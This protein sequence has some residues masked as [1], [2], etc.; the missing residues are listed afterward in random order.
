MVQSAAVQGG[1]QDWRRFELQTRPAAQS[2]AQS[3][4]ADDARALQSDAA[5]PRVPDVPAFLSASQAAVLATGEQRLSQCSRQPV[6]RIN[7]FQS[8]SC[9]H[10]CAAR[11]CCKQEHSACSCVLAMCRLHRAL[12]RSAGRYLNAVRGAGL[13]APRTLDSDTPLGGLPCTLKRIDLNKQCRC[14]SVAHE[15]GTSG[16]SSAVCCGGHF[17]SAVSAV[18]DAGGGFQR[19]ISAACA[20]ASAAAV[21]LLSFVPPDGTAA[22]PLAA[23][24]TLQQ[25]RRLHPVM[26]VI[27]CM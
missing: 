5:Q 11:L 13:A 24:R 1:P 26:S 16:A 3:A 8:V 23:L 12:A 2:A 7:V 10:D 22:S 19:T 25:V 15:A 9:V 20:A 27:D 6:Q 21:G 17:P 18:F 4:T 14:G